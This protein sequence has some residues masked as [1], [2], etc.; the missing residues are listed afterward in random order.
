MYDS[1][2]YVMITGA[3][4]G[5]G[6]ITALQMAKYGFKVVLVARNAEKLEK[7]RQECL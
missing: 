3:S 7:V 6:R 2:S 4:D 1:D 5:I